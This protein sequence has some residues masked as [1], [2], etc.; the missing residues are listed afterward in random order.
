MRYPQTVAVG[1][2]VYIAEKGGS[3][4]IHRYDLQ[5]EL[6]SVLPEYQYWCFT[7]TE[8]NHK[9]LLVGGCDVSNCPRKTTSTVTVYST[10][11]KSWE[12]PYPSMN[13]PRLFPTASTYH[14]HLVVVGGCD[15]S[16]TDLATVEILDTSKHHSQWICTTPLPVRCRRMSTAIIH[17]MLYLLGGTLSKQVL[18]I[19][20]PALTQT[21]KP[22]PQWHTLPDAP[23]EYSTAIAVHG[24]LLVVGGSNGRQNSSAIHI[25]DQEKNAWNKMSN[26]PTERAYCTCCLLPSGEILVVGGLSLNDWTSRMDVAAV[27]D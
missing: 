16:F 20:L 2:A 17:D 12:K 26:L 10:S 18:G 11:Q 22:P 6:W 5:T 1:T 8:V 25:Y 4:D 19:S 3:S 13:T 7:M 24:S 27:K 23:L 15:D 14:Q 9:L 21:D